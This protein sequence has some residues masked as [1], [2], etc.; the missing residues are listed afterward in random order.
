MSLLEKKEKC[1][2]YPS[3]FLVETLKRKDRLTREKQTEVYE[4]VYLM[5][6][7]RY[8]GPARWL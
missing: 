4:H 6:T 7:W 1:S 5:N 2:L 3:E 8:P